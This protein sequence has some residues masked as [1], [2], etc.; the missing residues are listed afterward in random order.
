M[1][2]GLERV[3][4]LDIETSRE[5]EQYICATEEVAAKIVRAHA[6]LEAI[7]MMAKQK[8]LK[9]DLSDGNSLV[10]MLVASKDLSFSID[11]KDVITDDDPEETNELE[12]EIEDERAA[13]AVED[14]AVQRVPLEVLVNGERR[15]PTGS[16]LQDQV[17]DSLFGRM[18][19][20]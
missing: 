9:L 4:F 1:T 7:H 14:A 16:V 5:Q 13:Q 20:I 10:D 17:D 11:E 6:R 18:D 3:F 2:E 19:E 8:D 12:D 15:E